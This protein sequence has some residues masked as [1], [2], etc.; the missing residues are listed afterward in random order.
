[1]A[2]PHLPGTQRIIVLEINYQKFN[3]KFKHPFTISKGTKTHQPILMVALEHY[4]LTG[5]GEA[6]AISYYNISVEDMMD[7]LASRLQMIERFAFIEPERF[8]HF[9]HHL[10]PKNHFLVSFIKSEIYLDCGCDL[11]VAQG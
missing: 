5:Y 7:D 11:L 4:G 1:M 2:K 8:W 3:L 9:L 10:F 6:P